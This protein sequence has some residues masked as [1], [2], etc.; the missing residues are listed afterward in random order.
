MKNILVLTDFSDAAY[1]ALF[2]IARLMEHREAHF[3]LLNV[4][5]EKTPI[6]DNTLVK[7]GKK[8]R[9][10]QLEEEAKEGLRHNEHKIRLDHKN[11]KHSFSQVA[12]EAEIL[13][14]IDQILDS[15]EI[16]FVVMGNTGASEVK[17]VF[18]GSQATRVLRAGLPKPVLMVPEGTPEGK[19]L[20]MAFATD[21]MLGYTADILNPLIGLAELNG[22]AI[23]ILHINAEERLSGEQLQHL[24][25]LKA[26]FG[27]T[28]HTLHW[29]PDFQT[30]T[31]AIQAFLDKH[32][33]GLLAMVNHPHGF[34]DRLTRED[35]IRD[36]SFM[37]E[38]P[39]LILTG[40]R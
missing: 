23:R 18:T 27:R 8:P 14:A 30:K 7:T 2:F 13:S 12:L 33:I 9:M 38:V 31:T 24:E 19:P 4:Y 11:Q 16:D 28:A 10:K 37:I 5:S 26:I 25:E 22:A 20:E 36:V 15:R 39:F 1:Q 6:R 29:I 40:A 35:V 34:L 3:I 17:G 21:F 32:G